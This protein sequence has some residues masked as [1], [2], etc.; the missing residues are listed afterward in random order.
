MHRFQ[1]KKTATLSHSWLWVLFVFSTFRKRQKF[2][3]VFRLKLFFWLK[4]YNLQK[5]HQVPDRQWLP[6]DRQN[7]SMACKDMP[8]GWT[9]GRMKKG[10]KLKFPTCQVFNKFQQTSHI[11]NKRQPKQQTKNAVAANQ[12]FFCCENAHDSSAYLLEVQKGSSRSHEFQRRLY[13]TFRTT[14]WEQQLPHVNTIACKLKPAD[15]KRNIKMSAK[16]FFDG[17]FISKE[18]HHI[19]SLSTH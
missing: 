10:A 9:H 18:C 1:K 8:D 15:Q 19:N 14:R 2:H 12:V 4:E 6:T 5:N 3:M 11:E 7:V 16:V 13:S 17:L